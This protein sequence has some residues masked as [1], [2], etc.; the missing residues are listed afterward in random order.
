MAVKTA[1][2]MG[3]AQGHVLPVERTQTLEILPGRNAAELA[4]LL[5]TDETAEYL[6]VSARTVKNLLAGGRLA[7][8]KIGRATRIHRQDIER[9]V[10]RNRRKQR[11][12]LR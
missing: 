6:H 4:P 1:W 11:N 2:K 10:A 3:H 9:Y 7:Y 12:G 8:I 5:T